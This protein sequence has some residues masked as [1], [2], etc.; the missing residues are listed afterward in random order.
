MAVLSKDPNQSI[1]FERDGGAMRAGGL[2]LASPRYFLEF[3]G[4]R[5]GVCY[6]GDQINP[7]WGCGLA[8][9][10]FADPV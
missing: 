7:F 5:G 4:A 10:F 2:N 9:F 3:Q 6:L 8:D 1:S